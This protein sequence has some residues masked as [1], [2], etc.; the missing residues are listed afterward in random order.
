M[1]EVMAFVVVGLPGG[2]FALDDQ[3]VISATTRA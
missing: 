2:G 1:L 3:V